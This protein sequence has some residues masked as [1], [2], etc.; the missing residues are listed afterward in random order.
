MNFNDGIFTQ[1]GPDGLF[2][3]GGMPQDASAPAIDGDDSQL[4]ETL[5]VAYPSP[6]HMRVA[7]AIRHPRNPPGQ[8]VEFQEQYRVPTPEEVALLKT[9]GVT[10]GPGS[11]VQS[12]TMMAPP[13]QLGPTYPGIGEVAVPPGDKPKFPFVKVGLGVVAGAVGFWAFCKWGMP[14]ITGNRSPDEND[15]DEE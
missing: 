12:Q 2:G 8:Q 4:R 14:M 10:V 11:M 15:A 1:P 13:S 6:G 9:Q 5:V 3:R 7:R